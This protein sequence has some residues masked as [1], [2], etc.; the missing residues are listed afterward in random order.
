[1]SKHMEVAPVFIHVA[2]WQEGGMCVT[3]WASP[4][5]LGVTLTEASG[6]GVWWEGEGCRRF[7]VDALDM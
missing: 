6:A 2:T 4:G 1:M 5:V 3:S 7:S